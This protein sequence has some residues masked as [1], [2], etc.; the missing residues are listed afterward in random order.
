MNQIVFG[1][2]I[3]TKRIGTGGMAEVF[4]ARK[5]SSAN[6]SKPLALKKL[7]DKH[8]ND[9]EVVNLFLNEGRLMS[10]IMHPNVIEVYDVGEVENTPYLVME[11]IYGKDLY[12]V[13][14]SVSS[15]GISIPLDIILYIISEILEG[16]HTI[17][18]AKDNKGN[19]LKIIHGDINPSNIFISFEGEIKIG[20]FGIAKSKFDKNKTKGNVLKGKISYLAPEQIMLENFNQQIDIY[21]AGLIL[22]EM[23]T[24]KK[25]FDETNDERLLYEILNCEIDEIIYNN[26][27]VDPTLKNIVLKAIQKDPKKRYKSAQEFQADINKFIKD[28]NIRINYMMLKNFMHSLYEEQLD[29]EALINNQNHNK[30]FSGSI[31]ITPISKIIVQLMKDRMTGRL[32]VE[33]SG[34]YKNIYFKDGKIYYVSSNYQPELIGEFIARKGVLPKEVISEALRISKTENLRFIDYLVIKGFLKPHE[35]YNLLTEQVKE[36]IYHL[37]SWDKGS[38][39]YFDKEITKQDALPLNLGDFEFIYQCISRYTPTY[40]IENYIS[41]FIF[42]PIKFNN[43]AIQYI[44]KI[45]FNAYELRLIKIAMQKKNL[46]E[47]INEAVLTHNYKKDEVLK[48]YYMLEIIGYLKFDIPNP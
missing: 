45:R 35:M 40:V 14:K 10:C 46:N 16:L 11:Y 1:N 29:N 33:N 7:L 5:M 39:I 41:N 4:L 43:D 31:T 34:I 42:K 15:I 27:S 20:D 44:E 48:V 32:Y 13:I 30:E 26:K 9:A 8:K 28:K 2:Y 18:T 17:H 6:I 24:L 23:L 36:K 21:D 25:A 22:Y 3:L 12:S 47:A 37:L 19:N 38:Y